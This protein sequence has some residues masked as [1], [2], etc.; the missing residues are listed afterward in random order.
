MQFAFLLGENKHRFAI[1]FLG[2]LRG[3]PSAKLQLTSTVMTMGSEISK[4]PDR[5]RSNLEWFVF[6]EFCLL[7]CFSLLIL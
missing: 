6:T 5:F 7:L 4:L 2:A 1:Q 3:K